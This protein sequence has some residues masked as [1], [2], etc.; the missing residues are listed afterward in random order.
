MATTKTNWKTSNQV[1]SNFKLPLNGFFLLIRF[2]FILYKKLKQAPN[3]GMVQVQKLGIETKKR[4]IMNKKE[5]RKQTS[6]TLPPAYIKCTAQKD[7]SSQSYIK[8]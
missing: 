5:K 3:M 8:I 7:K 2:P 1:A 4:Y 6:N